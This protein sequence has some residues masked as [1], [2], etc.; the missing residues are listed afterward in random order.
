M[1]DVRLSLLEL[2]TYITQEENT[3][4]GGDREQAGTLGQLLNDSLDGV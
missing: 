3:L 2:R 4:T 1:G